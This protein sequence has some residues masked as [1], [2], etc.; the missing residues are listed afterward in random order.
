MDG[1]AGL[2]NWTGMLFVSARQDRWQKVNG[3]AW[4]GELGTIVGTYKST[5]ARLINGIN[6]TPGVPFWQRNYY[7]HIIRSEEDLDRIRV[8]IQDNPRRWPGDKENL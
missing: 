7:E 6:H 4:K 3:S 5:T 2:E 1:C 8:Y